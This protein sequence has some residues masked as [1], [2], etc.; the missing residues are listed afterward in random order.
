MSRYALSTNQKHLQLQC[1]DICYNLWTS[2]HSSDYLAIIDA[3]IN[4]NY[5]L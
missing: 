4:V 5:T 2:L 1:Q 3:T